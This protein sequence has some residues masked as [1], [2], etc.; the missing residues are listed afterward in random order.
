MSE[1]EYTN[2]FENGNDPELNPVGTELQENFEDIQD[3]INGSLDGSNV[4]NTAE[5]ECQ[6]ITTSGVVYAEKIL[7]DTYKTTVEISL[8]DIVG[9][10]FVIKNSLDVTIFEIDENNKIIIGAV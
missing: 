2:V 1:L 7:F 3:V 10:K 6:G 4:I 9:S 8:E 5:I